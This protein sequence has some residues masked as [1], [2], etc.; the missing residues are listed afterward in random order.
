MIIIYCIIQEIENKK[1]NPWGEPKELEVYCWN[2]SGEIVYA[3]KHSDERYE[4]PIKTAYKV[5][6]RESKRIDGKVK[7]KIWT[8]RTIGYYNLAEYGYYEDVEKPLQ[9]ISEETGIPWDELYTI[10]ENK[11]E[12]LYER[13]RAEYE[14]TEE[15]KAR[16]EHSAITRKY[17]ADKAVFEKKY[18]TNTYARC[19]DVFGNLR[20]EE[21]L[22]QLERNH[23]YYEKQQN[24]YDWSRYQEYFKNNYNNSSSYQQSI[25]SNYNEEDNA[26]LKKCFKVL[27]KYFHPDSPTG[28]TELMQFINDKLKKEWNL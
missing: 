13:V 10:V 14:Q 17:A 26:K 25:G 2:F 1:L 20:N 19:Y 16:Q 12:P 28:D 22:K 4:R 5:T 21:Y 27:A 3:Y 18:G 8:L 7:A 9:R 15:Y 23:S 11:L 6:M 24:N